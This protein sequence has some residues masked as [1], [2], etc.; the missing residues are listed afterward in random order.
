MLKV[1]LS[2][3]KCFHHKVRYFPECLVTFFQSKFIGYPFQDGGKA[4]LTAHIIF[5]LFKVLDKIVAFFIDG[6]ICQVHEKVREVLW[7]RVL[8]GNSCKPCQAL[9]INVHPQGID[10]A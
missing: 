6:V 7:C 4:P 9:F 3:A 2:N 1:G 8:V 5:L 10:A